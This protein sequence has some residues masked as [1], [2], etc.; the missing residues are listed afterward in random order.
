VNY[1]VLLG[2]LTRAEMTQR[3]LYHSNNLL[4]RMDGFISEAAALQQEIMQEIA[5]N[6]S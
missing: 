2:L 5:S 3:Q 1:G 4:S 6:P